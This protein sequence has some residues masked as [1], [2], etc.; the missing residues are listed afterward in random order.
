M[1]G[2]QP[3]SGQATSNTVFT[4]INIADIRTRKTVDRAFA[5]FN[6][7]LTYTVTIEN[8]GNVLATNV[9]FQDPIPTGT[10]FIPNSVTVDGVSQPG[11]NPATGFTVANI[12]RWK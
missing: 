2:Q 12:S 3:I 10:T 6:D 9:I 1:P 7:V 4:T 8:T 11:A 5:T